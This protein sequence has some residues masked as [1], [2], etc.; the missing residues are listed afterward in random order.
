MTYHVG[1]GKTQE[2]G[3]AKISIQMRDQSGHWVVQDMKG[4]G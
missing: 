4:T 3:P 1:K 2:A